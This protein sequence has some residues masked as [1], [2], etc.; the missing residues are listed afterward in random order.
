[1]KDRDEVVGASGSD[2]NAIPIVLLNS[3]RL[4]VGACGS[5]TEA[6]PSCLLNDDR[7]LV[8]A[9][10]SEMN[11]TQRNLP[12]DDRIKTER[13]QVVDACGSD[14]NVI[15]TV[16][17][18]G[19][20]LVV[21]A[22][23]SDAKAIPSRLLYDDRLVVDACGSDMHDT[24]TTFLIDDRIET[25]SKHLDLPDVPPFP[26]LSDVATF[27][28]N[29]IVPAFPLLT[30]AEKKVQLISD[31]AG[32]DVPCY[33]M[34]GLC[35][36]DSHIAFEIDKTARAFIRDNFTTADLRGSVSD[37]GDI[38]ACDHEVVVAGFPCQP[39]SRLGKQEGWSDSRGRGDLLQC[40][41]D[42]I[43]SRLPFLVLLENVAAFVKTD[44][45]RI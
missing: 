41:I 9:C 35:L 38:P 32:M 5:Y 13:N 16:L 6:F 42:M 11:A 28:R 31:F 15:P 43:M 39:F 19:S 4:V 2:M 1:M 14:I 27:P 20:R 25:N 44:N 40:T 7:L 33:A 30:N 23:G 26:F 45:G 21:G 8:D 34:T 12:I 24:H 29:D 3:G 18:N 37:R 10:G 22:R 36:L 17:L